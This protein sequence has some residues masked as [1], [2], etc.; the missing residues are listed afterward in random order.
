METS[1]RTYITNPADFFVEKNAKEPALSIP[2]L[3]VAIGGLFAAITAYQ[4]SGI[5]GPVFSGMSDSISYVI[6]I[7]AGIS[8]FI[9]FFI[10]WLILGFMMYLITRYYKSDHSFKRILEITGYGMVPLVIAACISMILGLYFIPMVEIGSVHLTSMTDPEEIQQIV[11]KATSNLMHDPVFLQ[12]S[13]MSSL[14]TLI[15]LVW[16][17]NQWIFGMQAGGKLTQ[18]Q[19]LFAGGIPAVIYALFTLYSLGMS[20]GWFST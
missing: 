9:G 13:L 16:A 14:V 2:A 11:E 4:V 6:V 10:I 12:Y 7:F 20:L 5:M 18:K 15:F 17:A 3:I 1:I 19:V 8:G